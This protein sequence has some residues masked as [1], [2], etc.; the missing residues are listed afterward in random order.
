MCVCVCTRA[1]TCKS[2]WQLQ[3]HILSRGNGP[4]VADLTVFLPTVCRETRAMWCAV[5]GAEIWR[6]LP[7]DCHQLP[8]RCCHCFLPEM[9]LRLRHAY[10]QTT[11]TRAAIISC[12]FNPAC[13]IKVRGADLCIDCSWSTIDVD[14]GLRDTILFRMAKHSQLQISSAICILHWENFQMHS[15][16]LSSFKR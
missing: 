4:S 14:R 16:S 11:G 12:L 8:V 10:C 1:N 3:P 6:A 13:L 2:L 7:S 9:L 15:K 5:H